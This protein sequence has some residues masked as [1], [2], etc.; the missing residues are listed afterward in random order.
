MSV[1]TLLKLAAWGAIVAVAMQIIFYFIFQMI[2]YDSFLLSITLI[3][4][5]VV[6]ISLLAGWALLKRAVATDAFS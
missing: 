6:A 4:L 1:A 2:G 5:L 3:A